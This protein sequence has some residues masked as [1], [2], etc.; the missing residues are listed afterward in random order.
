MDRN[1]FQDAQ[2]DLGYNKRYVFYFIFEESLLCF[3]EQSG[4]F[5]LIC[6]YYFPEKANSRPL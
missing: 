4:R 6:T 3:Y 1:V 5:L 2:L